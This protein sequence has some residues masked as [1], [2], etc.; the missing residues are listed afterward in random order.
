MCLA[1][2][3]ASRQFTAGTGKLSLFQFTQ[4]SDIKLILS[5]NNSLPLLNVNL[6]LSSCIFF[7]YSQEKG[8]LAICCHSGYWPLAR[9][10]VN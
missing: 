1:D 6:L 3:Q 9:I 5:S 7:F 4:L 8:V 2:R 10:A